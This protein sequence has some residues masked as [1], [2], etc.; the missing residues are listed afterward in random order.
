MFSALLRNLDAQASSQKRSYATSATEHEAPSSKRRR[1]GYTDR[2]TNLQVKPKGRAFTSLPAEVRNRIW[3]FLFEDSEIGIHYYA[4]VLDDK[5]VT[6]YHH[7]PK[8]YQAQ[9]TN[10]FR[11]DQ[12]NTFGII[13]NGTYAITSA[14]RQLRA[15]TQALFVERTTFVCPD[16]NLTGIFCTSIPKSWKPLIRSFRGSIVGPYVARHNNLPTNKSV[17]PAMQRIKLAAPMDPE[18]DWHA[19]DF[20][21]FKAM[22]PYE[23][24]TTFLPADQKVHGRVLNQIASDRFRA[25][26]SIAPKRYQYQQRVPVRERPGVDVDALIAERG[27]LEWTLERELC[28]AGDD[29]IVGKYTVRWLNK[30]GRAPGEGTV[31][32]DLRYLEQKGRLLRM[33]PEGLLKQRDLDGTLTARASGGKKSAIVFKSDAEAERYGLRFRGIDKI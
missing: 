17:F 7:Q 1:L 12:G 29:G 28:V 10:Q 33:A 6:V 23:L 31:I 16:Q 2:A 32:R 21:S 15:E 25:S 22:E 24:R 20:A 13:N 14:N 9:V 26:E 11:D 27:D 19:Y 4:P 5:G 18:A 30:G 8:P 3:D